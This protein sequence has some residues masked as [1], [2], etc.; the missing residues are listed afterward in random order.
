MHVQ[1]TTIEYQLSNAMSHVEMQCRMS[2]YTMA[3]HVKYQS[4]MFNTCQSGILA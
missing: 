3:L 1:K 2:T 4:T